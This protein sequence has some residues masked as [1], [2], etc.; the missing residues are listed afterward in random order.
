MLQDITAIDMAEH[1]SISMSYLGRFLVVLPR[2]ADWDYKLDY[3]LAVV[4]RLEAN[5]TGTIDMMQDGTVS[6]IPRAKTALKATPGDISASES[7]LQ[8]LP[9]G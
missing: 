3:L 4:D 2:D 1:D 7:D 5:E 6:F 8:T 9:A